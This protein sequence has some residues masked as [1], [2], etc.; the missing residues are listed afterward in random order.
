MKKIPMANSIIS[1]PMI[2]ES[3]EVLSAGSDPTIKEKH[4][5]EL[6]RFNKLNKNK[7]IALSN[8]K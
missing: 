1:Q 6:T 2:E 5:G 7:D 8:K 3:E 4:L